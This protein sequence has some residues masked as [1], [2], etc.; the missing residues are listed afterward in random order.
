SRMA[1]L[2][3]SR[4]STVSGQPLLSGLAVAIVLVLPTARAASTASTSQ[5]PV[6]DLKIAP[7]EWT[8]LQRS[9]RL[10]D[11]HPATFIVSNKQ[12]EVELRFRGDWARSWPK[13]PLKIFFEKNKE[14]DGQHVLNLNPNWRDPAFIRER[15]AYYIYTACGA[16]ASHTRMVKLN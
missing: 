13:K 16:P 12:Y 8:K 6:Y 1:M 3:I 14:F 15:L 7:A 5:L 10:D 4:R 2:N 9:P 11:R